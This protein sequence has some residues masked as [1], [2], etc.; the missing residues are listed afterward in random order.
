MKKV[1]Q[2]GTDYLRQEGVFHTVIRFIKWIPQYIAYERRIV[3][4]WLSDNF[5]ICRGW[6]KFKKLKKEGSVEHYI[7]FREIG[8]GIEYCEKNRQTYEILN[9]DERTE[10]VAPQCFEK[11]ENE[12][13]MQYDTP[14]I[15]FTMFNDAEVYSGTQL[16]SLGK[17]IISDILHRDKD[18]RYDLETGC[19]LSQHRKG[20]YCF[21]AF[22]ETNIVLQEAITLVGWASAN[23]YHFTF[24]LLSRLVLI[25]QYEQ[26]RSIPVLIDT[27]ALKVP[28]MRNLFNKINIYQHPII[29]VEQFSRVHVK[30][31]IFVSPNMWLPVNFKRGAIVRNED[32]LMS[33]SVA[34]NIRKRILPINRRDEN[35]HKKIFLSRRKRNVQRL[36]NFDEIEKIFFDNGYYILNPEELS[37]D[38]QVEF[39][40]MQIL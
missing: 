10:V 24:E 28:Q 26:Y 25:D 5:D 7:R 16:I 4:A 21:M 36:I 19:L 37:F 6:I 20:K 23:Y 2:V 9:P 27:D 14:A 35:T 18:N 15:Y 1:F 30:K 32:F 3:Q 29:S 40:R 22:K 13:K 12:D 11:T 34:D 39:F 31:L 38:L 17:V 33:R 8:G